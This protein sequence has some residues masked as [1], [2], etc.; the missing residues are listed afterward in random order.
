MKDNKP[1]LINGKTAYFDYYSYGAESRYRG[2]FT[3]HHLFSLFQIFGG[4]FIGIG[5]WAVLQKTG[6]KDISD[7]VTDPAIVL[8]AVGVWM[9]LIN[10][11]G[12][13]GALRENICCLETVSI[14]GVSFKKKQLVIKIYLIS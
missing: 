2:N 12:T 9:F 3:C 4:V 10:F 8:I 11:I 1:W 7:F 13:V 5:A 6:Y 14:I